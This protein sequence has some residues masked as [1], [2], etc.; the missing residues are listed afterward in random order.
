MLTG[1]MDRQFSGPIIN[2]I[3]GKYLSTALEVL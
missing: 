3:D 2:N 1:A